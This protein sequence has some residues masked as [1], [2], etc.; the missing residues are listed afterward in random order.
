MGSGR[1][2]VL[3]PIL[4]LPGLLLSACAPLI[5]PVIGPLISPV[6]VAATGGSVGGRM[7]MQDR[8]FATGLEDNAVALGINQ[9]WL[10]ADPAIF[11]L[12]DT[13]VHEGRV[14][15][16]GRV[17]YPETRVEAVRLAWTVKGVK[18]LI[19]EIEVSDRRGLMD[20]PMD[21]WI[22]ARLRVALVFDAEV[23]AVNYAIDVVNGT[24]FVMGIARDQAELDRVLAL[25]R[26]TGGVRAVV[27]HVRLRSETPLA[28]DGAA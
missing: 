13:S 28:G 14:L 25:A 27:A 9:A 10:A 11:R 8:G 6:G 16:T 3:V 22:S 19:N 21:A 4:V 15:L 18:E 24:V 2:L 26:A 17:R 5:L 1:A 7:A 23:N 12:I 20:G